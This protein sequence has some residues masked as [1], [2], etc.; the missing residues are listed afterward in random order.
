MYGAC[1]A[2][3]GKR[4]QNCEMHDSAIPVCHLRGGI[5]PTKPN[6]STYI[7]VGKEQNAL[8]YM[9][10]KTSTKIVKLMVPEPGV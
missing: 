10:M 7:H 8:Y 9:S 2:L 5:Y 6:S 4:N 3:L 1:K